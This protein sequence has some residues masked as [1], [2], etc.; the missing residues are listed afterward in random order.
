M[1]S[2]KGYEI[3]IEEN[4]S[5]GVILY[6]NYY[7]TDT[8]RELILKDKITFKSKENAVDKIEKER[9]RNR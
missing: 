1:F 5:K 9:R 6:S 8:T 2:H 7:L 4:N 3:N